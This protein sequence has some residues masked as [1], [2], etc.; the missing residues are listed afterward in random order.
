MY[1]DY[2]HPLASNAYKIGMVILR[3]ILKQIEKLKIKS[4]RNYNLFAK[5]IY[6]GAVVT[7]SSI[8]A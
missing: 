1:Y 4:K 2:H 6:K 5:C 8:D 7:P 3:L